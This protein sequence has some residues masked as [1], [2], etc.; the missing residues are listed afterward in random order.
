MLQT[1]R[2]LTPKPGLDP[3]T[4][5]QGIGA[6]LHRAHGNAQALRHGGVG[7]PFLPEGN[8]FAFSVGGHG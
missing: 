1:L 4:L 6:R 3:S 2:R 5:L 8:E 7:E